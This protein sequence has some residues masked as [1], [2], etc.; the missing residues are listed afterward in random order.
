L[1]AKINS[2]VKTAIYYNSKNESINYEIKY[3]LPVK[4]KLEVIEKIVNNSVDENGFYNPMRVR[5]YTVLE[6]VEAYTNLSFTA[7]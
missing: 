1:D 7:K 3:Y 2:E 4:E 5:I 6:L